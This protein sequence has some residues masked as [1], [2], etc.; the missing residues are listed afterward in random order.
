MFGV[1]RKF[2]LILHAMEKDE[3]IEKIFDIVRQKDPDEDD[4]TDVIDDAM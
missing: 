2:A 4:L 3:V 1:F